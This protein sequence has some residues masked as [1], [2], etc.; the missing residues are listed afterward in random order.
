MRFKI[1]VSGLLFIAVTLVGITLLNSKAS[2]SSQ[3]LK[4]PQVNIIQLPTGN[5][6]IPVAITEG[7]ILVDQDT[8]VQE[9]HFVVKNNTA[10]NIL[11]IAIG[12]SKT[13][14]DKEGKEFTWGG[15]A[16]RDYVMHPDFNS[17][18]GIK[19][20]TPKAEHPFD[21][22][23]EFVGESVCKQIT[24]GVEYV[25]LENGTA[26]GK[27]EGAS[28]FISERRSGAAKYKSWLDEKYLEKGRSLE[29]LLALI[30]YQGIPAEL[31]LS[32]SEMSGATLFK[33]HIVDTATEHGITHIEKAFSR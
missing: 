28:Q 7:N 31:N 30:K 27:N 2:V 24:I 1:L 23:I 14:Q 5:G 16:M 21:D 10:T 11:A 3:A 22:P 9:L 17:L 4:Q 15:V 29:A 33:S 19:P 26:L 6:V 13:Y 20:F 12:V 25:E 8:N 32:E 18:H